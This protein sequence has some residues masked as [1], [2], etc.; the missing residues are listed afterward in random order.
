[1][2]KLFFCPIC[3]ILGH[4]K[5][6][7]FHEFF[8]LFFQGIYESIPLSQELSPSCLCVRSKYN[9]VTNG[10]DLNQKILNQGNIIR[11]LKAKTEPIDAEVAILLDLKSKYEVATGKFFSEFKVS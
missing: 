10:D 6:D 4:P 11:E 1:M 3:V 9:E 8:L 7:W 5:V 2:I